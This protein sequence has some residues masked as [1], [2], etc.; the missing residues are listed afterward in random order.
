MR[1]GDGPARAGKGTISNFDQTSLELRDKA[2][3]LPQP[4]LFFLV[5][6]VLSFSPRAGSR[7]GERSG[8]GVLHPVEAHIT[9]WRLGSPGCGNACGSCGHMDVLPFAFRGPS[10]GPCEVMRGVLPTLN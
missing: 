9:V 5:M 1:P 8:S 10:F 7:C 6:A 4:H 3:K 2:A